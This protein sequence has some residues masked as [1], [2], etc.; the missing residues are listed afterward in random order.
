MQSWRSVNHGQLWRVDGVPRWDGLRVRGTCPQSD[1]AWCRRVLFFT[2]QSSLLP[3]FSVARSSRSSRP[4]PHIPPRQ[5]QTHAHASGG[6]TSA[7]APA[8]ARASLVTGTHDHSSRDCCSAS[9]P[10]CRPTRRGARYLPSA[11]CPATRPICAPTRAPR[12][13]SP[14]A[15][16]RFVPASPS[17]AVLTLCP[18]PHTRAVCSECVRM[19]VSSL[20]S[21][22]PGLPLARAPRRPSQRAATRLRSECSPVKLG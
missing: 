13:P 15:A 9:L 22:T 4:G 10:S 17:Q 8:T 6:R 12:S 21:P 20:S 7:C 14:R 5:S 16:T 19:P 1:A 2:C 3:D 11:R 18:E